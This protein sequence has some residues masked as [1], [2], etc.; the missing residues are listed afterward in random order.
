M[1][2]KGKVYE[3]MIEI[4]QFKK[5]QSLFIPDH[6]KPK[7]PE[8]IEHVPVYIS[9]LQNLSPNL[10]NNKHRYHEVKTK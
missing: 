4:S 2:G 10:N 7:M 3:N 8:E 5:V 6:T 1:W 9:A